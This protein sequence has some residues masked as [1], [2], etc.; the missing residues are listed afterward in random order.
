M[1][2]QSWKT[3]ELTIV[4]KQSYTTSYSG[5]EQNVNDVRPTYSSKKN[6]KCHLSEIIYLNV[7][8]YIFKTKCFDGHM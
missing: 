1:E 7:K 4:G 5:T 2:E 3:R 8:F 6:H